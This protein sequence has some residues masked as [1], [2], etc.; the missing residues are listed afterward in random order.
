MV[1]V[2]NKLYAQTTFFTVYQPNQVAMTA[3]QSVR[4]NLLLNDTTIS[5]LSI[6]STADVRSFLANDTLVFQLPGQNTNVSAVAQRIEESAASGYTWS[7]SLVNNLGYLSFIYQNNQTFG[8]I[9]IGQDFYE[10]YPMNENYEFLVKKDLN[11]LVDCGMG[12]PPPP[13]GPDP[14]E[15]D[16]LQAGFLEYNTCPAVVS[17]LLVITQNAKNWILNQYGSISGFVQESQAIVNQAMLNSDIPN[18]TVRIRWVEKDLDPALSNDIDD[19]RLALPSLIGSDRANHFAD[20]AFLVTKQGY[21]LASGAVLAIG[22]DFS[23]AFGIVEAN[24]FNADYTFAHELGHLLGCRHNWPQNLGNDPAETSAH[25]WRHL[26]L[27]STINYENINEI[28]SWRTI[29]GIDIP[30][31]ALYELQDEEDN[32][33]YVQIVQEGKILHYSNPDVTFGGIPTGTVCANNARQIR[34]AACIVENFFASQELSVQITHDI[35]PCITSKQFF[36]NIVPPSTGIQGV[37]PYVVTWHWSLSGNFPNGGVLLGA[38]STLTLSNHPHCP[39]YWL[40]C[41]VTS[42]DGLIFVTYKKITRSIA[43]CTATG[44]GGGIGKAIPIRTNNL[45]IGI[46][47]NPVVAGE[48]L[49]I[50][51]SVSQEGAVYHVINLEGKVLLSGVLARGEIATHIQTQFLIPGNYILQIKSDQETPQSFKFTVLN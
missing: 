36:A 22:P 18:K 41:A 3:A 15:C 8:F 19:D 28:S 40:K 25:A 24:Y 48:P 12:D 39:T 51:H 34:N 11:P 21:G 14:I 45:V 35:T 32:P 37:G 26:F 6:V 1:L 17:V 20:V 47:P 16:G 46:Q 10:L 4:Y 9:Q 27:P 2:S 50:N 5:Q 49:E 42:S 7:A 44:G 38:G 29:L 33:Y 43:C 31:A 30:G 23:N 13:P